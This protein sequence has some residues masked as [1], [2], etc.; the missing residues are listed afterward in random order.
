MIYKIY[1]KDECPWCDKAKT[2]LTGLGIQYDEMK[3]GKDFTRYELVKILPDCA[4]VTVPQVFIFDKRI[5][6]YED[7]KEYLELHNMMVM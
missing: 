6:G 1:S 2:L 5:G 7:L 4:K 3:L